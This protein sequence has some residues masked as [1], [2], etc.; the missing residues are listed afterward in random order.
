MTKNK[1]NKN[2]PYIPFEIY[3]Q[4][5]TLELFEY[6]LSNSQ[7]EPY[8]IQKYL[9]NGANINGKDKDSNK[10]LL[11]SLIQQNQ[12]L[13]FDT[14]Q[15]QK[16]FLE[17]LN[18]LLEFGA[19]PN[20]K[21]EQSDM[22]PLSISLKTEN[23]Q[24]CSLLL[25]KHGADIHFKEDYS[26]SLIMAICFQPKMV[27]Y[28]V[29]NKVNINFIGCGQASPLTAALENSPEIVRYL[30]ENGADPNLK[31]NPSALILAILLQTN[32]FKTLLE[33][34]ADPNPVD[35][36]NSLFLSA[37]THFPDSLPYLLE[38]GMLIN[39]N[40]YEI[41]NHIGDR[42]PNYC[43]AISIVDAWTEQQQLKSTSNIR[44]MKTL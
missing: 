10:T 14:N 38:A 20:L 43:K 35:R 16:D 21:D 8:K 29:E 28:L 40:D 36:N 33:F 31:H 30:L 32:E 26:N 27:K 1:K 41:M 11:V 15:Y 23:A 37:S 5:A 9:N 3:N 2:T 34:K 39:Q 19:D 6:V 12:G 13:F 44:R 25:I 18:C 42:N 22:T 17:T 7:T 4:Q 24:E